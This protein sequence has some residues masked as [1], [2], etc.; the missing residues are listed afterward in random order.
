VNEGISLLEEV[1]VKDPFDSQALECLVQILLET[2][3]PQDALDVA[4]R[5]LELSP[6]HEVALEAAGW[7]ALRLGSFDAAR[8]SF[9]AALARSPHNPNYMLGHAAA[10]AGLGRQE[11]A[12]EAFGR[13]LAMYPSALENSPYIRRFYDAATGSLQIGELHTIRPPLSS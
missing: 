1:V 4:R 6:E 2:D 8:I 3:R 13:V 11:Q 12:V 10:L 9:D 5:L 7:A